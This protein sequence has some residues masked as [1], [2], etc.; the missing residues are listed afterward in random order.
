MS[1]VANVNRADD[2]PAMNATDFMPYYEAP[3]PDQ[4]ELQDRI[5]RSLK[6]RFGSNTKP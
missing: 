4:D 6:E 5:K 3:L 1:L 2:A